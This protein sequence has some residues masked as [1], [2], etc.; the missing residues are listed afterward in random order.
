MLFLVI[1]AVALLV[2]L[3]ALVRHSRNFRGYGD[4]YADEERP[5]ATDLKLSKWLRGPEGGA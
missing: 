4:Q 2:V 3:V 1:A 5:D